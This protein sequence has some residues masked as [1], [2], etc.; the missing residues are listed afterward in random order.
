[1][2]PVLL[3]G[4][5][6]FGNVGDEAILEVMAASLRSG[7]PG[8]PLR[9]LT[10]SPQE[11]A[12]HLSR[13]GLLSPEEARASVV[14]RSPGPALRAVS[15][16]GLV[17]SGGG[18][19]LQE[20]TS[21]RSLIYYL[22]LLLWARAR[23][24]PRM[25]FAQGVG[26][27]W[28]WSSL[29]LTRGAL[30][31]ASLWV[32]DR[33]SAALL[34]GLGLKDVRVAADPVFAAPV[35]RVED[36]T[37]RGDQ[38]PPAA[39]GLI[40]RPGKGPGARNLEEARL[41]AVVEVARA[42]GVPVRLIPFQARVELAWARDLAARVSGIQVAEEAW[43]EG[44]LTR[45]LALFQGLRAVVTERYH[46]LAFAALT[47]R[48]FL[49]LAVDP[50][51]AHLAAELG[52]QDWCLEPTV[53]AA[54]LKE[55]VA[56]LLDEGRT[57]DPEAVRRLRIRAEEGLA[58]L[59]AGAAALESSQGMVAATGRQR[60]ARARFQVL[61]LP[62]DPVS[63][64]EA[65]AIVTRWCESEGGGRQVITSNPELVM[66]ARAPGEAGEALRAV[67]ARAD[68]VVAD[69]IGLVW[70]ARLLGNALP[71][72]VAGADLAERLCQEAASR[73]WRLFLWGGAPGVAREAAA[74][75][76]V[77]YPELQVVG[78]EHGY[79]EGRAEDEALRRLREARP[80]LLLVGMGAPRQELW[81]DR[82]RFPGRPAGRSRGPARPAAPA[83]VMIGVGGVLDV[84]AGRKSRAP[85]WV[86]RLGL[87]WL[88]RTVREPWRLR[89]LAALPRF[90]AAVLVERLG[91]EGERS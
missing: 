61:G 26:P 41:R 19:L 8:V 85:R 23:G 32:R 74:R 30:T 11:T 35:P 17:V 53:A 33:A 64:E 4:Y 65:V 44:G 55:G 45:W 68:L 66:R 72:R 20:R 58:A 48:P 63:L 82:L 13:I 16:A 29:R 84:W 88:Y 80:D 69:G 89:R 34:E 54:R 83:R 1:M 81:I 9:I 73:G 77:R 24:V 51:L 86:Q 5:Y 15:R 47:G 36:T 6:G 70:G 71:G 31:G 39:L 87:E 56:R 62:V 18:G 28:R 46:G 22:A 91:R 79:L 25:V 37:A 50:K 2:K 76:R 10:A 67:V 52:M 90:V 3:S 43:D 57:P 40:L 12:R 27:L 78:T 38:G 49:V 59:V 7:A 75:L 14:S 42:R 21:R 60:E